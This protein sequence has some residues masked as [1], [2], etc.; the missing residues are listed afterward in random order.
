ML[1]S[2]TAK[3]SSTVRLIGLFVILGVAIYFVATVAFPSYTHRYRL[4]IEV[5]TQEGVR[6]G[7]SVIEVSTRPSSSTL[8]YASASPK[9]KG[10][11]VYVDLGHGRNLV[12]L[13]AFGPDARAQHSMAGLAFEVLGLSSSNPDDLKRISKLTGRADLRGDLIPTLVTFKDARDPRSVQVVSPPDLSAIGPGIRLKG[14]WIE[15]TQ[16]VVT[17]GIDQRL[18]WLADMERRGLGSTITGRPGILTI[19]VPY[20]KQRVSWTI[21]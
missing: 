20:F 18:P 1:T 8:F 17:T 5:D 13:M 2:L 7:S 4:T 6:S 10:E 15:M 3:G 9:A 14:A 11:A 19:N 12:A 21:I 16:D